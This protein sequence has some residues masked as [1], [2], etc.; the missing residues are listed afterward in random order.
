MFFRRALFSL[1]F[2]LIVYI[3]QTFLFFLF[4]IFIRDKSTNLNLT[5]IDQLK[6]FVH[7]NKLF[8]YMF[9]INLFSMAGLPPLADFLVNFIYLNA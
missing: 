4:I 9:A 6:N 5:K 2:Y 7:T 8:G 3:L 1:I